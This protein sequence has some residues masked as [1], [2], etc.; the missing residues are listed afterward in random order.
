MRARH[1][2]D[3]QAYGSLLW[4]GNV[5]TGWSLTTRHRFVDMDARGPL[6]IGIG[7]L[8]KTKRPERII[9]FDYEMG[10]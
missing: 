8:T 5:R 1:V 10:R 4:R 9:D 7:A 2:Q 3:L 6:V